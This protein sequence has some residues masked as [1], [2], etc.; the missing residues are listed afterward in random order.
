MNWSGWGDFLAM[1]GYAA[2]VWG[3]FAMVGLV[4]IAELCQL[5]W[6][7]RALRRQ[8]A[9]SGAPVGGGHEGPNET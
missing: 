8:T 4:L 1:G 6:R 3:A 7:R 2:Y 5:S 9:W